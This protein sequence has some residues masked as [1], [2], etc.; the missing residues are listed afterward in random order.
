MALNI[1][2]VS[3]KG[4]VGKSTVCAALAREFAALGKRTLAVDCDIRLRSLDLLLGFS[5]GLVFTWGDVLRKQCTLKQALLN[6][7]KLSLLAAPLLPLAAHEITLFGVLLRSLQGYF[8]VIL[9]DASAGFSTGFVLAAEN[10]DVAIVVAQPE[11]VCVRAAAACVQELG[12]A[13]QGGGVVFSSASV[14]GSVHGAAYPPGVGQENTAPKPRLLINRFQRKRTQ[15]GIY[16]NIDETIDSVGAQLVG[17][18]PEDNEVA[19]SIAAG[20]PL[21]DGCPAGR[22]FGRVAQRLLGKNVSLRLDY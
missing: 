17:V 21:P 11:P 1:A 18:I 13:R 19:G 8:D 20:Y 6:D 14:Q 5:R 4:G 16:F 7:G 2:L 3:G 15:D 22:A 9:L 12:N 10:A